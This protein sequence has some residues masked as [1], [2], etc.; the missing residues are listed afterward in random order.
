MI[1]ERQADLTKMIRAFRPVGCGPRCLDGGDQQGR[2]DPHDRDD[3]QDF[4]HGEAVTVGWEWFLR[5]TG[6]HCTTSVQGMFAIG[7]L[8]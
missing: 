2:E 6:D 5:I 8:D 4:N 3:H 1:R 7:K